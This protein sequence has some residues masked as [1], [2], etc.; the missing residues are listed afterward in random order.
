MNEPSAEAQRRLNPTTE[1]ASAADDVA[2]SRSDQGCDD[3]QQ[4]MCAVAEQPGAHI[5]G[6]RDHHLKVQRRLGAERLRTNHQLAEAPAHQNSAR[7]KTV[8]RRWPW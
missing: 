6:E 1:R 2:P 4:T 3:A 7:P 5:A 8:R